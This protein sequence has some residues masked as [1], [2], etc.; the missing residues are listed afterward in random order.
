MF[1]QKSEDFGLSWNDEVQVSAVDS[2]SSIG[3]RVSSSGSNIYVSWEQY[4]SDASIY[5]T[6]FSLSL[7]HI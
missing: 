3:A 1:Y 4:D 6:E 5:K 2:E 7:I